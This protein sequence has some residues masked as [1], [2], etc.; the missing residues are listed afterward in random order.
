LAVG[1]QPHPWEVPRSVAPPFPQ[2]PVSLVRILQH[3]W[4]TAFSIFHP[5][6]LATSA[7]SPVELP[8]RPIPYLFPP[9]HQA[10]PEA[11]VDT[12]VHVPV[13]VVPALVQV[14]ADKFNLPPTMK[15]NLFTRLITS[16]PQ[17]PASGVYH[18][19]Y[20]E[21]TYKS[22]IH[23]RVEKDGSGLLIVNAAHIYHL[24]PTAV[25]MAYLHLEKHMDSQVITALTNRY[26]VPVKQARGDYDHLTAQIRKLIDPGGPCPVCDQELEILSPFSTTPSAPYRMDLA[27]TYLCNNECAHCYNARPRRYPELSTAQWKLILD[28]LWEIGIP[29]IVFTGGEPTLRPDLPELI[30]HAEQ[31]GQITGINT[32]GR[33]LKEHN[34]LQSLV[35]AGLDHIQITLE[36]H[37]PKTHD[38]MVA[39]PGA[40]LDTTAGIRNALTSK[41]FVMTNTT[42]LTSNSQNI[43]DT[44]EYL[45]EIG[46]PTIGLNALI[47][48]GR[49]ASVGSGLL[50]S[51]LPSILDTARSVTN[52]N[53][54]RL[55][56][57]TPTQYCHFDPVQMDLG[58]KGCTAALYNM[59]IEPDGGVI[60]C[61]SYYQTLG[62]F[63][64]KPW[65]SIWNHE[66][67]LDLRQRRNLPSDC[68]LCEFIQECGGGCPLARQNA[69]QRHQPVHPHFVR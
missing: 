69:P 39:S 68:Q 41:I 47:Y 8:I 12:A 2:C 27:I 54:Q 22:R 33:R 31:N 17:P 25:Y 57:Y 13:R 63:L 20:Q 62:N 44:L 24:N 35:D 38:E 50:E 37:D 36:S 66:L 42:L 1:I 49:G 53:N 59:C 15:P 6:L 67:A 23:L 52:K 7:P 16:P 34:Y 18:Y 55:I 9:A 64:E 65:E 28:R 40:W 30:A 26:H 43:Q 19:L 29:H 21:D 60:P 46:V 48:S 45:A 4:S 10:A 61:Q 5:V 3:P 11:A 58:V 32:N 56:W 51:K 14:E